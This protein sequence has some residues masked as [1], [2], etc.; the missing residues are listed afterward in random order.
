MAFCMTGCMGRVKNLNQQVYSRGIHLIPQ[1]QSVEQREGAFRL[2]GNTTFCCPDGQAVT[3]ADFYAGKLHRSTGYAFRRTETEADGSICLQLE[4]EAFSSPEAYRLEV[5]PERVKVTASALQG[6]FYGM[7][8]FMQLLPAEVESPELVEAEAWEAPCVVVT[9]APRFPYRGL[10]IDV[11]RHFTSVEGLKK[12]IDMLSTLKINYLHLHLSDY[13]GWRVEIKKYPKLTEVGS[14]RI[15]EYG[16][17]YGGFYTQ[18]DIRELVRYASERYVTLIPEIDVPG[19]SL[20][21]IAAY[22]ELSCTGETYPVMS[23]WG[24]FPV[25]FCPGKE[26][27]FEMLDGIFEELCGLFPGEYFHIGG[28]ECP[29]TVWKTCPQ[30]QRRIREEGLKA[31]ARHTAEERLQSYAI[32]RCE[33]MLKKYGKRLIGWDEILE[34][35]LAPDA[36]VMSWRGEQGGIQ[37]ALMNHPVVM[38]PTSGG[39]YFDYY[40]GDSQAEPFAWGGHAPIWKTYAYDPVPDTLK[41]M[42]KEQYILGVQAN[43][44]SECMYTED[45]VEYRVYPRVLAVAEVGWTQPERKDYDDFVRRLQHA[46]VRMDYH[47]LNY[48]IPIP[49]QPGRSMNH[50]AF[51]D[52]VSVAFQTVAPA[53]RM[54]YTLDGSEPG[55]KSAVYGQPL[56]FSA[57]G[58]VKIRSVLPSGKMSVVR[59]VEVEKQSWLDALGVTPDSRGLL[60]KMA[61]ARCLTLNELDSQTQWRDSVITRVEAIARL[62]PNKFANV[63]FYVA[64]ARGYVYIPEDGIY[65]FRSDNTWVEVDGRCAVNNEGQPQVNSKGGRSLALRKGW[66][67]MKVKQISNFIGGWNSQHRNSGSVSLRKYGTDQWQ[68]ITEDQIGFIAEEKLNR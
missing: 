53:E 23:R 31:D 46:C 33:Q 36:T 8:T 24:G 65:E 59:S 55:L 10:M 22:P 64:K 38:T 13:Q 30:C 39:M 7:S 58:M 63:E 57:S 4:P 21:A 49:E 32:A 67:A 68:K 28:D 2:D 26:V 66:H 1:P 44:W 9:D 14:K 37:S 54:V 6:L 62:R 35:G 50:V 42:G 11:A 45:V 34:G 12:H 29:K 61:D 27:M 52:T 41:A 16:K 18:D 51:L 47:Q 15:D 43:A 56:H 17:E 5:T 20:A 40:Q 25:V 60:L 3:V 19:H 48:F